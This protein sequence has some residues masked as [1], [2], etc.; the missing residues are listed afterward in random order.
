METKCRRWHFLLS[1]FFCE[2]SSKNKKKKKKQTSKVQRNSSKKKKNRNIV[3]HSVDVYNIW[4][5][6]V[7]LASHLLFLSFDLSFS[8]VFFSLSRKKKAAN[9]FENTFTNFN[10]CHCVEPI[11]HPSCSIAQNTHT[12]MNIVRFNCNN[13][14]A[15]EKKEGKKH[16]T[17]LKVN[18]KHR[19]YETKFRN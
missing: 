1:T 12:H 4:N 8:A 17:K 2:H 11:N 19:I 10:T 13:S 9:I 14:E 5:Y 6:G 18:W 7:F 15:T 16:W 3:Q